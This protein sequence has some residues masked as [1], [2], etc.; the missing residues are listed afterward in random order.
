MTETSAPDAEKLNLSTKIAY[1]V[2]DLGPV[3]TANV[4]AF[5]LLFFLTNVAGMSAGLAGTV[6]VIGKVWDAVNDLMVGVLSDRTR[7]RWGRRYPWI[8]AGAIPFSILNVLHW[9]VP[10]FT[11]D[12]MANQVALFGYYVVTGICFNMAYTAVTL[13]YTA[14]TPELTQDYHDRT[15]L[16]SVRFA[17][18][19]G[20]GMLSLLLANFIFAIVAD[21]EQRYFVLALTCSILA[22]PALLWGVWGTRRRAATFRT[23]AVT[24]ST[25]LMEQVQIALRNR[26]FLIVIGIY[27]CS[28]LAMQQTAA[29]FPYFVVNWMRLKE[30]NFIQFLLTV[31]VT[32]LVMQFVWGAV[33]QR[34]GK[35][36][37][38]VIGLVPWMIAHIGFLFVQPGQISLMY[39]LCIMAGMGVAV[40]YLVPWSMI[41]DVI[42]LDE[43][44][45]G[46]RREG[47]FYAFMIF[48]QKIGLGIG[49]FIVGLSLDQAGFRST[50]P[51]QP[52]P[53][54]P[55]SALLGI[56][57][58]I[59]LLPAI[60]LIGSLVLAYF[61]PITR[62]VHTGILLELQERKAQS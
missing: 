32:A 28:W 48:L 29:I 53:V 12:P 59:G 33:S 15:S 1:G 40:A 62:A 49:L 35:K 17:F 2:G 21:Q 25:P 56:R 22:I 47:V 39:L 58:V 8:I 27:L 24:E 44:R 54:Q 31:Q 51:G 14:L 23:I 26:P 43:L 50:I 41:P 38:Y 55:A 57:L 34:V 9:M 10:H 3:L 60:A 6:L 13:P 42:D 16:N 19:I 18:S 45:T 30:Q 52:L 7:S 61:Y 4:L 20:G 36:A 5:F 46:Q 11:D 37:V